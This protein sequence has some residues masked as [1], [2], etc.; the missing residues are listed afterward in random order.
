MRCEEYNE[1]MIVRKYA[2]SIVD[3][4][5]PLEQRGGRSMLDDLPA[6]KQR[7]RVVVD[8]CVQTVGDRDERR[9]T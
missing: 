8:D 3:V 5:A 2:V 1:Q 6:V 4:S 9:P 7:D